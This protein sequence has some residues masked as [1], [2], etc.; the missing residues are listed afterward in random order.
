MNTPRP[1]DLG[2]AALDDTDRL[3]LEHLSRDGR[4]SYAEIGLLTNLSATAVRRRIDRLRARGVV[5][6]FTVV[7]DP[8]LLGWRTEAFVE[9]YC[10]ARTSPEE[11]LASL[12]QFPEVAAAWTV[13]GDPD[14]LVHLRA[15]DTRHL[16]AV[17][18]RIRKEPG[19]QR[20]RSSVVLSQ[21]I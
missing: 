5:R 9:V 2:Q 13:T 7:L 16:E 17:I 11:L 14:A 10:R 1:P 21:L 12:R 20:S 19:V 15:A 3:L 4:A 18:E 8:A 6:G